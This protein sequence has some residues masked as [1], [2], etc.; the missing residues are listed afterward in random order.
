[1]EGNFGNRQVGGRTVSVRASEPA[2]HLPTTLLKK[3]PSNAALSRNATAVHVSL[4]GQC[5][6][7]VK[8]NIGSEGSLVSASRISL[9]RSLFTTFT[10][11]SSMHYNKNLNSIFSCSTVVKEEDGN[12]TS[13]LSCSKQSYLPHFLK[14]SLTFLCSLLVGS[15]FGGFACR[16]RG[17]G[18]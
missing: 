3:Y 13:F 15:L 10:T 18:M 8:I 7:G 12:T 4:G 6:A 5:A 11:Q 16:A 9:I 17:D 2:E 14:T 1:M